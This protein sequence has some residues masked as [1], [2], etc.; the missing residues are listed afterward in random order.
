MALLLIGV[1]MA[2]NGYLYA[3]A[4]T[5]DPV[6]MDVYDHSD[7]EKEHDKKESGE[8]DD[9][10]SHDAKGYS[11]ILNY[12]SISNDF[13]KQVFFTFLASAINSS[14]LLGADNWVIQYVH[15]HARMS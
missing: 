7:G 6:A 15:P 11:F 13:T 12:L 3:A 14:T 8:S 2:N 5:Q 4:D 1:L 10:I 9:L